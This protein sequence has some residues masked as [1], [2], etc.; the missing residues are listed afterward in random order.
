MKQ[1]RGR[2]LICLSGFAYL[3]PAIKIKSL[4]AAVARHFYFVRGPCT[5]SRQLNS[6]QL[7][8]RE[9]GLVKPIW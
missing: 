8:K 4:G 9:P 5:D 3:P 2:L 7:K 6:T 1:I